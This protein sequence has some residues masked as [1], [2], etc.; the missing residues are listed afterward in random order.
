M[1]NESIYN[2]LI[3]AKCNK[4]KAFVAVLL[5]QMSD[6]HENKE[7]WNHFRQSRYVNGKIKT[8]PQSKYLLENIIKLKEN[9]KLKQLKN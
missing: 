1:L 2:N 8:T 5:Q 6:H 7:S 3:Y 4:I 9:N